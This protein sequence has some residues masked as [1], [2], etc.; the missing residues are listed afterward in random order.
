MIELKSVT[1]PEFF[2]SE[3]I[4]EKLDTA[5]RAIVAGE[6][7]V[8]E[9]LWTKDENARQ[10]QHER[11]HNGKCCYCERK[12]DIYFERDVEHYRPKKGVTEAPGHPGY[13]WLAYDWDNLLIS[14]Q[15]CNRTHKKNH[16]PLIDEGKRVHVE[17]DINGEEPLLINPAL[18]NPEKYFSYV[19]E[20]IGGEYLTKITPS[21]TDDGKGENTIR[22][23]KLNRPEL[24]GEEERS[25]PYKMIKDSIEQ[26]IGW[27]HVNELAIG[28]GK[29]ATDEQRILA[30]K[31]IEEIKNL[32]KKE[33]KKTKTYSGFRR[34]LVRQSEQEELVDMLNEE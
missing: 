6:R 3:I 14:C 10:A 9:D 13:W 31:Y 15:V 27:K 24:L 30:E 4:T 11:H 1:R 16:F 20:K 32:I 25:E 21:P 22:I 12:R 8:L 34:F 29:T 26:F 33:T 5:R 17:G 2:D 28:A 7:P 23:V 19:T 18:E